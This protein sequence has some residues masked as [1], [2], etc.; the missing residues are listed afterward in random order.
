LADALLAVQGLG[1][2]PIALAG[3]RRLQELYLPEA[4][5][6]RAIGAFAMTEPEAGSDAAGMTSRAHRRGPSYRLSGRKTVVSNAGIATVY[7]VF[8]RE[9][10]EIS[11]FVVERGELAAG[12]ISP[13]EVIAPHPLGS[14]DLGEVEIPAWRR[15]GRAGEGYSLA[16]R[17]LDLFRASVGAAAC[18]LA[19]RALDEAVA[20]ARRR[21]QFGR[22][23][24]SFQAIRMKLADMATA[25]EASRALVYNVASR[26]DRGLSVSQ[27]A[28]MA[29]LMATESAQRIIDEAL[30]IHGGLGVVKG[31]PVERLYRE[32]RPLRIY[33]GTSEILKLII[34]S[35]LLG[36][37]P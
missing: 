26:Y 7:V 19:W 33:E 9:G 37:S 23:L 29:K 12:A 22:P 4:S 24:S 13:I 6:G 5:A 17:T 15:L 10:K 32:I 34:A 1:T 20:H 21:V 35:K 30:Q 3:S 36:R 2:Y 8:A 27:E 31:T 11:A 18:G 14:V 16:M 25:L 28:A